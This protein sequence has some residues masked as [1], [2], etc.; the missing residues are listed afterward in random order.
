KLFTQS[1]DGAII[2]QALYLPNTN[3]AGSVHNVVFVATMHDSVYAFDADNADGANA[4]PLWR[5]SFLSDGVVPI[6]IKLQRCAG[7][8]GWQEVGVLSTPVIDPASGTLF[9]VAKTLENNVQVHRLHALDVAT[10]L[11]KAGSP[12]RITASFQSGAIQYFFQDAF[13]VNRPALMLQNGN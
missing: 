7:T 12:I 4:A 13:Q 1:V 2:G 3:V 9:V 11:E 10:G 8:T 6:P 5:T